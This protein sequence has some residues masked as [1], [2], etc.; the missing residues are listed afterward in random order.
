MITTK[1]L[2]FSDITKCQDPTLNDGVAA[3][4]E[5]VHMIQAKY[6]RKCMTY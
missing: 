3:A 2:Y 6:F 5:E 1:M 4:S